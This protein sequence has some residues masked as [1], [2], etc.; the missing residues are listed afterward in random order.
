M[1][2]AE[3]IIKLR[4]Q[5]GWSQED[6]AM[7][8]NVSRQSV[9]KWESTASIPDLDKIVKLSEIFGVSTDYLLKDTAEEEKGIEAFK[10][11]KF[12]QE[13]RTVQER[14]V[15]LEEANSYINLVEGASKKIAAGVMACILS[16]VM[17]LLLGVWAENQVIAI[18]EDMAGGIG[19]TLLLLIIAGAV[20]VF[21]WQGMK[22]DKF[23]YMEKEVLNLQYGIA[24]MVENK[25]EKFELTR[26]KCIAVGVIL[27]I[28]SAVPL[29]IAAGFAASDVIIMYSVC[30]LLVLIAMG[31]YLFVWSGMIWESYLK[32]LE[33]GD[34]TREKKLENKRNE[35]ISKVYWC[36]VTAL[37]L[38]Y[39]LYTFKWHTSWIIWP[40]AGVLYAAVLG[41]AAMIRGNKES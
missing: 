33:E 1:I 13:Q 28:V 19:V 30:L 39:S 9:S 8:L 36:V 3:K 21:I 12:E 10:E 26:K 18:S 37:Y 27:C 11:E 24:G 29:M 2:L 15:S 6:L 16:P 34:Y 14:S 32:L 17:L 20:F 7:Q 4:K 38:G 35:N 5:N 41:V 40:C 22:L 31:V 25:K 23:E